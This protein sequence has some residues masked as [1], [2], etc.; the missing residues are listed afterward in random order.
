[1]GQDGKPLETETQDAGTQKSE[2]AADPIAEAVQNAT[3][4]VNGDGGTEEAAATATDEQDEAPV[5]DEDAPET[6]KEPEQPA[7]PSLYTKDELDAMKPGALIHL[8]MNRV[9][10]EYRGLVG[11]TRKLLAQ[12][13][14]EIADAKKARE[15]A[16][17]NG[18]QKQGKA[19]GE[20]LTDEQLYD[21]AMEG[22]QGFRKAVQI[23]LEQE[24]PKLLKK[25]GVDPEV[26][27]RS[28]EAS[29]LDDAIDLASETFEDLNDKEFR[30]AVGGVL[31]Q[32]Q[33]LATRLG[34]AIDKGDVERAADVV[35]V[36]AARAM[37]LKTADATKQ[38]QKAKTEADKDKEKTDRATKAAKE[39]SATAA[40]R[41]TTKGPQPKAGPVDVGESVRNAVK[42]VGAK[43]FR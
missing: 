39:L 7:K 25:I 14:Q 28:A 4:E 2:P 20:D 38:Q 35:E 22:P 24:N 1:M 33:K 34:D 13:F 27:K 31:R 10:P 21:M 41:S 3:R 32:D 15:E 6:E 19:E 23:M 9:P 29:Y 17:D 11:A 5:A 12:G 36:A 42:Q 30:S 40:S 8:D 16:K 37:K 18:S 43:A 26:S